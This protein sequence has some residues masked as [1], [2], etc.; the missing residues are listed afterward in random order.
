ME[1]HQRVLKTILII[2][3]MIF[4]AYF[5]TACGPSA[6]DRC[7]QAAELANAQAHK[8]VEGRGCLI[9]DSANEWHLIQLEALLFV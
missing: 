9:Q 6:G 7:A 8:W 1:N 4:I 5:L 2:F 3:F